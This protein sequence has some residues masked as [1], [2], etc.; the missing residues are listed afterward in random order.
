MV[1]LAK[2]LFFLD[3]TIIYSKK[4]IKPNHNYI[5]GKINDKINKINLCHITHNHFKNL[6]D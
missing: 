2:I 1:Y 4:F 3:I 5:G 6:A